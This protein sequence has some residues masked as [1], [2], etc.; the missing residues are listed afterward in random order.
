MMFEEPSNDSESIADIMH[1]LI[2]GR[3]PV[4]Q[5]DNE[6]VLHQVVTNSPYYSLIEH[7]YKLKNELDT[8]SDGH[9]FSV[10]KPEKDDGCFEK[11]K[12]YISRNVK[13]QML[14]IV[15]TREFHELIFPFRNQLELFVN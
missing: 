11:T 1:T 3:P 4:K 5:I 2:C 14:P 8:T 15:W 6:R 12:Y 13:K 9:F 10:Q 7:L